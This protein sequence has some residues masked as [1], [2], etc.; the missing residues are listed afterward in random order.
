VFGFGIAP[1]WGADN[2]CY[3]FSIAISPLSAVSDRQGSNRLWRNVSVLILHPHGVLKKHEYYCAIAIRH[4]RRQLLYPSGL[5]AS[6]TP[7]VRRAGIDRG[8]IAIALGVEREQHLGE[9]Q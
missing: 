6:P 9:V 5:P 1:R 4:L 7:V 8:P 3:P 2:L